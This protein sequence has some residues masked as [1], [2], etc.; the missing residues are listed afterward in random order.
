MYLQ[1]LEQ[2]C[3]VP[4]E[5]TSWKLVQKHWQR[6]IPVPFHKIIQVVSISGHLMERVRSTGLNVTYKVPRTTDPQHSWTQIRD[7]R[8][9]VKS[10]PKRKHMLGVIISW[11]AVSVPKLD[12]DNDF[13]QHSLSTCWC[14]HFEGCGAKWLWNHIITNTCHSIAWRLIESIIPHPSCQLQ[15]LQVQQLPTTFEQQMQAMT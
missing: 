11:L 2:P 10:V 6:R 7:R 1:P 14:P 15:H 8:V 12:P 5:K 13:S 4:L 3:C 9:D